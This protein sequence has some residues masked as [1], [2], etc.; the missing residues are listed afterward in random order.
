MLS[1]MLL[2]TPCFMAGTCFPVT[3]DLIHGTLQHNSL[4]HIRII[5]IISLFFVLSQVRVHKQIRVRIRHHATEGRGTSRRSRVIQG[6]LP[7]KAQEFSQ[8]RKFM[9]EYRS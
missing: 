3:L 1:T 7:G 8:H 5:N 6:R 4:I 9:T 2:P